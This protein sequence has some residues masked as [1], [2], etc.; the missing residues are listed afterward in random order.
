MTT[1]KPTSSFQS[2]G[3]GVYRVAGVGK[4]DAATGQ[5]KLPEG[6]TPTIKV[7]VK[8]SWKKRSQQRG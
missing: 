3:D 5:Y 8:E 4:R 6:Y 1:K 7:A 2:L